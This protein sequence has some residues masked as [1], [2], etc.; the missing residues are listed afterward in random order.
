MEKNTKSQWFWVIIFGF[1]SSSSIFAQLYTQ[2]PE[3]TALVPYFELDLSGNPDSSYQTP[4]FNRLPGCCGNTDNNDD[5][6]SFYVTLHPDVAMFELIVVDGYADPSGSGVYNIVSGG[7]T[8]PGDCGA[9][10]PGGAPI[11]ISGSGPH[12]ITYRKPGSNDIAYIFRQIPKPIYPTNQPTRFGCTLPL[13]IYGL[14]NISITAIAKSPNC[15][16][17]LSTL[18][19][20]MS[21]LNCADPVFDPGS[22]PSYPYTVTYQVTGTPQAEACGTYPTSGSFTITVYDELNISVT[23]NPAEFCAGGPGVNLTASADGGDGNYNFIWLDSDGDT[24]STSSSYQATVEGIYTAIVNDGLIS[25]TCEGASITVPV[26]EGQTP[27]VSAG[28]DK[29]ACESAPTVVLNG[30]VLYADPQWLGGL[31][32]ISPNR[33]TDTVTYTPTPAEIAAGSVTLT[34]TSANAGGGCTEQSDAVT[35]SYSGNMDIIETIGSIVCYGQ[36]TTLSATVN[37][38]V[39]PISYNWNTGSTSASISVSAGTYGLTVSDLYACTHTEYFTVNQPTPIALVINST[40]ESITGDDGVV[41]VSVSGGDAPYSIT[42]ANASNVVVGSTTGNTL[43]V[44]GL[45]D[46]VYTA[47]V[48][49][50]NGCS[51]SSSTVVNTFACSGLEVM[52]SSTGVECYGESN[53][54]VSAIGNGGTLPENYSFAWNTVPPQ[55]LATVNNLPAGTYNVTLTD[56]NTGCFDITS[57]T[58]FQPTELTNTITQTNVTTEGGSNGTAT[59]NPQ[60]GTIPFNYSWNTTPV[61][62]TQMATG[63]SAGT[64][65]VTITDDN[66]CFITDDVVI[67]QPPCNDFLL[68]VNT[69]PLLCNGDNNASATVFISNGNP[70]FNIVWSTGATNVNSISGLAAGN[71]AVTVS[72]VNCSTSKNFTVSEPEPLSLGLAPSN[73][74]CYGGVNGSI[75]LTVSGGTYPQYSYSWF[76][77][78]K[79]IAETQDVFTL[80]PSTYTIT[81]TDENGCQAIA[82]IGIT[83]P[84]ELSLGTTDVD[85]PC[86]GNL[87]GTIDASV[88][89]GTLPYAYS[90]VGPSGYTANTEDISN[91]AAGLYKLIVTDGNGC[92]SDPID[93]YI[94]QPALLTANASMTNQVACNGGNNGAA[95]VV[96][97]GGTMP[98]SYTWTG[99]SGY[100]SVLD[101]IAGIAAGS[102]SVSVTDAQ[103]CTAATSV[104]ITT[105]TDITNPT[106]TCPVPISVNA[107]LGLCTASGVNLGTPVSNDNCMVASVTNNAPA[108]YSLGSSV[109]IWTVTDGTGNTASCN[110]TVTV[111]DNQNPTITCPANVTDFTDPGVCSAELINVALGTPTTGD[112]CSVASIINNA[113]ASFNLGANTVVWTVTDG[114]G[115]TASCNQTITILD[116]QNPTITCPAPVSTTTGTS[117]CIATS[118]ILGTPVTNDNCSILNLTNNAPAVYPLGSTTVTWT[119]TDGSNNQATCT[120]TVTVTDIIPP[121]ILCPAPV[122]TN[123]NTG[124]CEATGVALGTPATADNCSVFNVTNNA[125]NPFPLGTTTVTW[126]VTDGSNNQTTCT[127]S[128]TVID[129]QNPTITCPTN[130]NENA[131]PG[132]CSATGVAL[133]SPL[134]ADNCSV[135]SVTNN[136]PNPFP[137]GTTTVTWTVTD[138]SGRQATCNQ[139][140]NITDSQNPTITCPGPVAVNTDLNSCVATGVVLGTPVTTDNCSSLTVT[141]NAPASFSIGITT[142]TWTVTDGSSNAVSCPQTVTVIDNQDPLIICPSTVTV[143]A[144]PGLC[145]AGTV[146]LGVPGTSDN[147]TIGSVT[148]D[149]PNPFPLGTTTVLWTVTDGSGNTE[150]CTQTVNVMD[151]QDPTIT[152]SGPVAVSADLG[153]CT[154][155]LSNVPLGTPETADNCSVAT[156]AN[157][158]PSAF[159]IGTTIVTWTVTDGSGNDATCTQTVTIIDDQDP[160]IS[161]CPSNIIVNSDL[162]ECG[163]VVNWTVPTYT[164]N[165]GAAMT[166]THIPGTFFPVATTTVTYTVTDGSNNV[167]ICSFSVTVNDTEAPSIT[168]PAQIET[169][170]PLVN[171]SAPSASDNCEVSSNGV[172]QTAGLP[173]GSDFPV[174][175]TTNAFE[176]MDIHG[177]VSTCSFD[178]VVFP[179]PVI[180]LDPTDVT[181]NGLNNGTIDATVSI[182]TEPYVYDWSNDSTTEDLS[183]MAPGIYSL[184]VVDNNGCSATASA[185]IAEPEV[186]T[187]E[188]DD[189]HVT[190]YNAADGAVDIFVEGGNVPYTFDWSNNTTNEDVTGLSGGAIDVTVTDAKGCQVNYATTI[191]EPDSL[192][193][194]AVTYAA[195]CGSSTGAVVLTV[196]G[197]TNPYDFNWSDG[198]DGINL[199]NV[200]AGDYSVTVTD[201]NGCQNSLTATIDAVNQLEAQLI[202]R[203]A[204]CWGENSGEIQAVVENGYAPFTYDWSDGQSTPTASELGAAAYSV[205]ITDSYGCEVTL[206]TAVN[207]PDSL[208]I[209][210]TS[211]AYA[212]GYGVSSYN[213]ADGYVNAD[214]FGGVSPYEYAWL[215]PNLFES[216]EQN[217]YG[218]YSGGYT[219]TVVDANGCKANASTRITEPDVLEMP[220][221]FSP[222]SDGENDFFEIHGI[223][224]YPDNDLVIYN[225]WGNIVYEVQ[226]YQNEW[227]GENNL[228]EQLPD[229]TYFAIL[230]I[231]VNGELV[232][233]H[234]GYIDLRR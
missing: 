211:S 201:A 23:P 230:Q 233:T 116:N 153:V 208:Y 58:V 107:D 176:V 35:I 92:T 77:D 112:N 229:A 121:T 204:K 136:A 225:R 145:T 56:N 223:D 214:V 175:T 132:V 5:Y 10:I 22:N 14:N 109:V 192:M 66:N 215:G 212:G 81:V 13:P 158:A 74:T 101:S 187:L 227:N 18:N 86:Y 17:S 41:N 179:L 70:P 9:E 83:Q 100:T 138:G 198:S 1:L 111:I 46:G 89:G 57:V 43:N 48:T 82:S 160:I 97:N 206:N 99:P 191:E 146:T 124:A 195:Q 163:A 67:N 45:S 98:Y 167:S 119:V 172:I 220:N 148:N 88:S 96:A 63:L 11:C 162:G 49:D 133:G 156:V 122:T 200:V 161:N 59:A 174:G 213:G 221:G 12:K 139:L 53:G 224:A 147:C 125:P 168:C 234:T 184:D 140:V 193:L 159:S 130:V 44:T 164:D 27:V 142:V 128:V 42:L 207:Q 21:C 203:D 189:T 90:W 228:G 6:V 151:N 94:S 154:T 93:D 36:T 39:D 72:D 2:L 170:D 60:G 150:T 169:C 120:Q 231:Y 20:Y 143:N 114:S 126:T 29:T 3:C 217:I 26:D 40:D 110:Q 71:Y 85:N 31:G 55:T 33:F 127:Q 219:L 197:G 226:S 103:N 115:N 180:T 4:E 137:L 8:S 183:G 32:T 7:M 16:A 123:T 173:S 222:N 104:S 28:T 19:T 190:C 165:C 185:T 177:N 50:G 68:A 182:G 106:I 117:N 209:Q 113:P 210:L 149:A 232:K 37:G 105:V 79:I 102:Y 78:G 141:N 61:Q 166:F 108:A 15:A 38:G 69:T 196:T 152:C 62:S 157:N 118:V 144:D 188:A 216:D 84:L 91:L 51:V 54:S 178:V 52:A 134:T 205:T 34:L 87:L 75:D 47:N 194:S 24:L 171:Y 202:V 30:S 135:F 155:D 95:E 131:D 181:C 65:S 76:S 199:Y 25:S 218:L 73:V 186:M 64:Y 80:P 129:N